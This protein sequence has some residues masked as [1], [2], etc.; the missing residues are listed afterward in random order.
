MAYQRRIIHVKHHHTLMFR[1]ILT[2]PPNMRLDNIPSV[3]KWHLA[4]RL[5]PHLVSR[6]RRNHLQRRDVNAKLSG[7]GVLAHADPQRQ[8]VV[9]WDRSG[10]IGYRQAKI[11]DATAV[12]TEDVAVVGRGIVGA[13]DQGVEGA[14]GVV[15][16]FGKEGFGLV[17]C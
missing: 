1:T 10:Q 4:I 15:G 6:M 16:Q 2:P 11:V 9:P 3:H 8:E 5:D 12:E 17:F 7:L 13:C 14:T